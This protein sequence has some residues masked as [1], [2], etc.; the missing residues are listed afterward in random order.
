[1]QGVERDSLQPQE[2][3]TPAFVGKN[4]TLQRTR[5]PRIFNLL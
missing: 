4:D 5:A 2:P 1:M 3:R